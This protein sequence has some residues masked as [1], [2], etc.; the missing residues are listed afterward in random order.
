LE[1]DLFVGEIGQTPGEC[2]VGNDRSAR[3]GRAEALGSW[4]DR[5]QQRSAAE[6]L[7]G[8]VLSALSGGPELNTAR[9]VSLEQ[10]LNDLDPDFPD[11]HTMR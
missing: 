6:K 2:N 11:A 9:I 3:R 5:K 1:T 10:R 7:A 8:R 4:T